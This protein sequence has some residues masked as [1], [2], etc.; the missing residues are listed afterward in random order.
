MH[1]DL[2][3]ILTVGIHQSTNVANLAHGP[4]ITLRGSR[5]SEHPTQKIVFDIQ[6]QGRSRYQLKNCH[7]ISYRVI[8]HCLP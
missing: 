1:F 7:Q 6:G 3:L 4:W 2:Y 5:A 8:D